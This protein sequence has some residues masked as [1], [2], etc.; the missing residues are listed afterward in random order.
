[1]HQRQFKALKIARPPSRYDIQYIMSKMGWFE[2]VRV[3]HGK[4]NNNH[5]NGAIQ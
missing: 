4:N 2:I 3:T 5:Q 1:M